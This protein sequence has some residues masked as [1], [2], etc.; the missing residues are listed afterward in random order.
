MLAHQGG[1]D[2]ALFIGG[3]LGVLA[4][5]VRLANRRA[6]RLQARHDAATMPP[7]PAPGTPDAGT[8]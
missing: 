7:S 8:D 4:W 5:L 6:D 3:T 2:E 1:W